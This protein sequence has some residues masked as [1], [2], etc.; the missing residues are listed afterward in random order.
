MTAKGPEAD[1]FRR[2]F[3][4]LLVAAISLAFLVV[5]QRFLMALL[6]AAVLSGVCWSVRSKLLA[7]LRGR[8]NAAS[9]VTILL[10][11][12]VVV[13]PLTGFMAIVASQAFE[14]S[15]T[16]EPWITER[17]SQPA[18]GQ[19]LLERVALPGFLQPYQSQIVTKL[20]ALAGYAGT[21]LVQEL[22][23]ATRGTVSFFFLLFVMLYSMFFFLRDGDAMLARVLSYLPLSEEEQSQLLERFVS[24]AR[25][26]I[27]GTLVISAVQGGL[28]GVAFAV[29]GIGAAAFWGT[30]MA[31]L[32]L[33]PGI[34]TALVWVPAVIYLYA[35]GEQ[36]AAI[37]L[38]AW[39]T[40]VVGT[41]DNLLR[42]RLVGRDTR[43]PDLLI[44]L[45]TLGGL[46][47]FGAV[48]ILVGPLVAALFL[49]VWEIYGIAFRDVLPAG[50][51]AP[52]S[53]G[54]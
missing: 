25:A 29:A 43:M 5:V 52:G 19:R 20:G 47:A 21:F 39:C 54:E 40:V 32:S 10:V 53:E 15:Q 3:L 18:D 12:I 30:V 13:V 42:P 44:F 7:W 8:R 14:V 6:L 33:I 1:R 46:V 26:T 16:V 2:I 24:V 35:T 37:G 9:L 49:T 4:L 41:V 11:L 28:A 22:A 51:A 17:V 23:A 34:G 31:V 48:G 38:A 45:S 36:V 50:S 27:R